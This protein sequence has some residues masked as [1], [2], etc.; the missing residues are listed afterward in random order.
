MIGRANDLQIDTDGRHVTL[1][2]QAASEADK[3]DI[4]ESADNVWGALGP[5]DEIK[6]LEVVKPYEFSVDKQANGRITLSGFVPNEDTRLQL[7][8][9]AKE[10]FGDNVE[11]N[12][13]LAAGAPEGNWFGAA[14]KAMDGLAALNY[15]RLNMI[16]STIE[17]T[18]EAPHSEDIDQI[19][20]LKHE[21][22]EGFSWTGSL[23][24][25]KPSVSPY[26]FAIRKATGT[27]QVEG[28]APDE[29]SRSQLLAEI[30]TVAEGAEVKAD[31][32]LADGTPNADW[33][34]FVSERLP[35][36]NSVDAG[37]LQFENYEVQL[38]GTVATLDDVEQAVTEITNIDPKIGTELEALDPTVNAFLNLRVSP[39][40]GATLSGA[41]PAGLSKQEAITLL[42]L[43][44]GVDGEISENGRGDANTWRQDLE[45][46]GGSL[47][48]F[49]TADFALEDRR[50]VIHGEIYASSD[51]KHVAEKLSGSL[52]ERWQTDLAID[53]SERLHPDAKKAALAEELDSYRSKINLAKSNLSGRIATLEAR[54][55]EISGADEQLT[56]LRTEIEAAEADLKQLTGAIAERNAAT[57]EFSALQGKLSG[58]QNEHAKKLALLGSLAAKAERQRDSVDENQKGLETTENELSERS[59]ELASVTGR[60][61]DLKSEIGQSKEQLLTLESEIDTGKRRLLDMEKTAANYERQVEEMDQRL[62]ADD[63][64]V[65]DT[66]KQIAAL[67]YE[68]EKLQIMVAGLQARH[69]QQ[70]RIELDLDGLR[71]EVE[72]VRKQRDEEVLLLT[73]ESRRV[74]EVSSILAERQ[75]EHEALERQVQAVTAELDVK[76]ATASKLADIEARLAE[77]EA[78]L[79][80][81]NQEQA[82]KLGLLGSLTAKLEQQSSLRD[83]HAK[84]EQRLAA[85]MS[86]VDVATNDLAA[87]EEALE[88]VETRLATLTDDVER[89][90]GLLSSLDMDRKASET[91]LAERRSELAAMETELQALEEMRDAKQREITEAETHLSDTK[92]EAGKMAGAQKKLATL[93]SSLNTT[94]TDLKKQQ[95]ALQTATTQLSS[96]EADA[97]AAEIRLKKANEAFAAVKP[98]LDDAANALKASQ[99]QKALLKKEIAQLNETAEEQGL[100]LVSAK[101]AMTSMEKARAEAADEQQL[102]EARVL[103]LGS[104]IEE[105]RSMLKQARKANAEAAQEAEILKSSLTALI[106]DTESKRIETETAEAALQSL[107]NEVERTKA[108]LAKQEAALTN[109]Q[110]K[111]HRLVQEQ[112]VLR[113]TMDRTR[114]D[115]AAATITGGLDPL[116]TASPYQTDNGVRI[117]HLLFN[118]GSSKLSPG[119]QRKVKEAASWIKNHDVRKIRLVGYA[120]TTGSIT[121]NQKLAQ[122][123]AERI[124][125]ALGKHG[126]NPAGIDI[127]A[128]G[129]AVLIEATDRY[130]PEPLNRSVGIFVEE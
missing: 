130:V 57:D 66:T 56:G 36:L 80:S 42:G 106:A 38:A 82:T 25:E 121:S 54:K 62:A 46:I 122:A 89:A 124:A 88:K 98:K 33:P 18:G 37:S 73:E 125:E 68:E 96:L 7:N 126:V 101:E 20:A 100:A 13:T 86:D 23:D 83:D 123:R 63:Q 2:G 90:E 31:I 94:Q 64:Q 85:L 27:W 81:L 119:T 87:R 120:D 26:T 112:Q 44:G 14:S 77:K 5:V 60:L 105:K 51:A 11:S 128:V 111:L 3:H 93:T 129:D 58:L 53:V 118:Y 65:V 99:S 97:K 30:Q 43:Q 103:Q 59:A 116:L 22:V 52:G 76:E 45:M 78:K 109:G 92:A 29:E 114:N 12:L 74:E 16:D 115:V 24:V 35:A 79:S 113:N 71:S 8:D 55:R 50:A 110:E 91:A 28:Y 95:E 21:G 69:E 67:K 70:Q 9:K 75:S 104:E 32:Q 61:A 41:L 127:D 102:S 72:A 1:R 108:T 34:G 49:E 40:A 10:K 107:Q 47:P 4:I 19:E 39:N 48:E 6:L 117:A 17:L 84:A 15:G